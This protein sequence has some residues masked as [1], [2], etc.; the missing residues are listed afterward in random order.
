VLGLV[1][2]LLLAGIVAVAPTASADHD[3]LPWRSVSYASARLGFNRQ[4]ATV[5]TDQQGGLY[6]FYQNLNLSSGLWNLN[7]TKFTT[8]GALDLPRLIFDHQVNVAA[9]TVLPTFPA[10]AMDESGALYVAYIERRPTVPNIY[11]STSTNGGA[12][13]SP[14]VNVSANLGANSLPMIAVGPSGSLYVAWAQTWGS[15]QNISFATSTDGGATFDTPANITQPG[16]G[17]TQVSMAVDSGGRIYIVYDFYNRDVRYW[18]ANLSRSDDGTTWDTSVLS[19]PNSNVFDPSVLA[20]AWGYVHVVW[21]DMPGGAPG[22]FY[23]RSEDRGD[24]WSAPINLSGTVSPLTSR[25]TIAESG[26]TLMVA[27]TS[28]SAASAYGLG[29]A[30]SADRGNSWYPARYYGTG[31]VAD[32]HQIAADENGTFYEAPGKPFGNT[33]AVGLDLWFGPPS[34][35]TIT[36][37]AR[38]T[39]QLTVSWTG[40]PE[41]NVNGYRLYRSSDGVTFSLIASL[42][43]STSS[44]VDAGLANGTYW[45]E[46]QAVND[47]AILSHPSAAVSASVGPSLQE[48]LAALQQALNSAHAD[49][50]A[51]QA[52]LDAVKSQLSSVQGNTTALQNEVNQLQQQLNNLQAAQAT[53]TIS[54]ANLA[55]EIIVV[56]LLVVLLLN[57]MR[58]PKVPQLMM[59]QPAQVQAPKNPEDE[60]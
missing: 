25:T 7:V 51:I 54:Y 50:A 52:Q 32:S 56:V 45:Y 21:L 4:W 5:F 57:Q 29:F 39:G 41:P 15:F 6:V 47:E 37:I 30:I 2:A 28:S 35:P 17:A 40:A 9:N 18:R 55:F 22:I 19:N 44:Y 12:S 46:V 3:T 31:S 8:R 24:T 27:W 16:G 59:A 60:L 53:Q 11:V 42:S 33:T 58:R 14:E 10:V 48:Q 36:D 34:I 1:L 26:G 20:D 38:D 49:L 43:A 23:S 13:W